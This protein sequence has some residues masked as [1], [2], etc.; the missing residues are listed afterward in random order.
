MT[1][2]A[3]GAQL[4][5]TARFCHKCGAAVA[6]ARAAGWRAGLPWGLAGAAL[7]ALVTVI[8]MRGAGAGSRPSGAGPAP[9]ASGPQLQAPDISQMSPEE[10]ATRLF[11]RIMTLVE[12]GKMDTAQFFVPMALGAY[13]QL[14][15][16][17]ADARYH[18]GLLQLAGGDPNA[19]L[20]E[21]DTIRRST[22][23]H[24]FI[25]ILRAHASQ[26]L[27]N[28]V[29]ER[30]AYADFLRHERAELAL[31]RPEYDEHHEPL[32]SF[33]AEALRQ[34]QSGKRAS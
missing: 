13:A 5:S 3:C 20:A 1:C 14:P 6:T 16:L 29:Q 10:R 23:T 27:G 25:Y 31:K 12:A 2:H 11:N 26:A 17:D 19:A 18:V 24:L 15:S 9:F 8:V 4:S 34:S 32:T 30:Q 7:G 28:K 21:A 22:P 33:H